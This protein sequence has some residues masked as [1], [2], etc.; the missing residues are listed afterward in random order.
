MAYDFPNSPTENQEFTPAGAQQTYIYK[1]P[2]WLLKGVPPIAGDT[3]IEGIGEA[4][5]DGEQYARKDAGWEIVDAGAADWADLTGKPST[6]PPTVPIAW[7]DVS[8]K[9]S[10]FPPSSHTHPQSEVTG[11]VADLALKATIASPTLTGDPKA[12]T[13]ATGDDDTSIATTAFVKAQGYLVDAPNDANQWV[14]SGGVWATN[15]AIMEAPVDANVYGR[16]S[17]N[18]QMVV[19]Y[20]DYIFAAG[21]QDTRLTDLENRADVIEA[22]DDSQDLA[23]AANTTAIGTK[24]AKNGDT[25]TGALTL[26]ADP[27]SALHPATKQYADRSYFS[28]Q[29]TLPQSGETYTLMLNAR[30]AGTITKTTVKLTSGTC[31]VTFRRNGTAISGGTHSASS[32]ESEITRSQAFSAGDDLT[33]TVSSVSAPYQLSFAVEMN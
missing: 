18:W 16:G 11:L 28:G 27:S 25:M 9:P 20:T 2:R 31:T 24:V 22:D 19:P 5:E 1:A 6:F 7:T 10:T 23:I 15:D 3:P 29:I 12:P 33:L 32:T 17:A 13:P 8:G 21:V 14:R 30:F 26:N 4:P